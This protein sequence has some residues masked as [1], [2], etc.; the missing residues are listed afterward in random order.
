MESDVSG[1]CLA[2]YTTT[3]PHSGIKKSKKRCLTSHQNK[4]ERPDEA[5]SVHSH[6][7]REIEYKT[8]AEGLVESITADEVHEFELILK[9]DA[10]N[11]INVH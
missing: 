1:D 6:S 3:G 4:R 11:L 10:G 8:N 9:R 2:T 7:Q 5:L